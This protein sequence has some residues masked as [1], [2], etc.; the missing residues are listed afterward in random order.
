MSMKLDAFLENQLTCY[1][2]LVNFLYLQTVLVAY[3]FQSPDFFTL[4]SLHSSSYLIVNLNT[5]LQS[6]I[7]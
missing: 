2:G 7:V 6:C 4:R 1:I 5:S 3:F